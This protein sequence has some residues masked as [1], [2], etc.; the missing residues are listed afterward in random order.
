MGLT[1]KLRTGLYVYP[2]N[3]SIR[4]LK[5]DINLELKYTSKS[6]F[7]VIMQLNRIIKKWAHY[8]AIGYSATFS[9]IDWYIFRR[10]F[11]FVSKKYPKMK[12]SFI[13]LIFFLHKRGKIR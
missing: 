7:Q 1:R 3:I 8:F 10:C 6:V 2:S 12:K 4:K 9:N 13:A 11:R 5:N